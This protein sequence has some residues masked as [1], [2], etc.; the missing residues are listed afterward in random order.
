MILCEFALYNY[1]VSIHFLW[2]RKKKRLSMAK[3]K[4]EK[5]GSP[6]GTTNHEL[7]DLVGKKIKSIHLQEIDVNGDGTNIRQFYRILCSGTDGVELI[8]A[9]D[10]GHEEQQYA[11]ASI[12]DPD[13]YEAFLEDVQSPDS[14]DSGYDEDDEGFSEDTEDDEE[15]DS[16]LEDDGYDEEEDP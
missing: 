4:K 13:D 1:L 9:C 10:G 2:T 11:T 7:S 14:E 12:M 3:G 8:L 6:R 16:F 5:M 15:E